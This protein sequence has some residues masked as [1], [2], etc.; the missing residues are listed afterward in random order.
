MCLLSRS[1]WKSSTLP[2]RNLHHLINRAQR[3]ERTT[4]TILSA[5]IAVLAYQ[6]FS[7]FKQGRVKNERFL[8]RDACHG[9]SLSLLMHLLPKWLKP[10]QIGAKVTVDPKTGNVE[11]VFTVSRLVLPSSGCLQCN[12]LIS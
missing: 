12:G 10:C 6:G 11:D 2:F 9:Y 5:C 8:L 3:Q 1:W 7:H 4:P